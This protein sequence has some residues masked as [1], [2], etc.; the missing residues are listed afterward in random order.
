MTT[1]E[2]D[3]LTR[4][5]RSLISE[6]LSS[7]ARGW[8]P[9]FDPDTKVVH[10]VQ[11]RRRGVIPLDEGEFVVS[12]SL[13]SVVKSGKFRVTSN[14]AFGE[15]IRECAAPGAGHRAETWLCP[16]IIELFELL[17]RSGHAHSV[18]AW[19]DRPEGPELV[20]G[21]YG[22]VVGSVFCGESMFARPERGGT[23]ASKVCLVHLVG[24]LRT[25]RF[26]MLDAQLSNP[27]L[28][29]FGC[30]E[31]DQAEYAERLFVAASHAREWGI[32]G[33]QRVIGAPALKQVAQV[34][35]NPQ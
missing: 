9:M 23:N 2:R 4:E 15:V 6:A 5:D 7:Y 17:H 14:L 32:F 1:R 25:Q 8:F 3:G 13:R 31:I 10:W 24:H 35:R 30:Y 29:Q 22:L 28:L 19:I 34:Q 18:E 11:P 26:T 33:R 16:E 21:L 20:G 12:R 27:H